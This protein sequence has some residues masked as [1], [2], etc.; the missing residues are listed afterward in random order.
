MGLVVTIEGFGIERSADGFR[1]PF[2][3]D[4][5]GITQ[6]LTRGL[7]ILCS[8]R[9][10]AE[11]FGAEPLRFG[12]KTL[13]RA[14]DGFSQFALL[15]IEDRDRGR[16]VRARFVAGARLQSHDGC[17]GTLGHVVLLGPEL[18]RGRGLTGRDGDLTGGAGAERVIGVEGRAAAHRIRH[19]N[20][21]RHCSGSKDRVGGR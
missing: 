7:S 13:K 10:A 2:F 21:L 6:A 8:A 17:L 11:A 15:P 4:F 9:V 18:D 19:G 3:L 1:P 16:I 20:G 14:C 12:S 5:G